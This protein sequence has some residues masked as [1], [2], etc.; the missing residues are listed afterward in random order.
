MEAISLFLLVADGSS[1]ILLPFDWRII[2]VLWHTLLGVYKCVYFWALA[3]IVPKNNRPA[4]QVDICVHPCV[5]VIEEWSADDL[6]LRAIKRQLTN[7][8]LVSRDR[9][10][11]MHYV[12]ELIGSANLCF[13]LVIM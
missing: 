1:I 11:C 5:S 12:Q 13:L 2:A 9:S 7:M 10:V 8:L 6:K 4:Y 3:C